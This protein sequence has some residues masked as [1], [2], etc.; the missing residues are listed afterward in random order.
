MS[1]ILD[2]LERDGKKM[3]DMVRELD[4]ENVELRRKVSTVS[5][6]L[7]DALDAVHDRDALIA[8]L[9]QQLLRRK[10]G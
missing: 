6:Q 8:D 7:D 9:Q 5:A 3:L 1:S 2:A 4:R 10:A